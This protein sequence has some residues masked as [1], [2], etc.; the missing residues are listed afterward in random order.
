MLPAFL[1]AGIANLRAELAE[2]AGEL[3]AARHERNARATDLGAVDVQR[4]ASSEA[5]DV[6]LRQAGGG[7][8]VAGDR[9]VV[10]GV[11]AALHRFVGHDGV[12]GQARGPYVEQPLCPTVLRSGSSPHEPDRG[13]E[14]RGAVANEGRKGGVNCSDGARARRLI[15]ICERDSHRA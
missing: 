1:G 4:D 14:P 15:H 2:R 13:V 10:A 3:A 8:V 6:L 5:L 9:A 11:D 7:A 12:L